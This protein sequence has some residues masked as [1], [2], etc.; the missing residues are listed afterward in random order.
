MRIFNWHIIHDKELRRIRALD[1]QLKRKF[2]PD[3]INAILD[4][5]GVHIARNP[6]RKAA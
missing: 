1:L 4:G 5:R 2:S 6:K 3:Q